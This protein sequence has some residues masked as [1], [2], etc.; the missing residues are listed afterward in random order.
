[1][2]DTYVGLGLAFPEPQDCL[3][4]NT[5]EHGRFTFTQIPEGSRV[6]FWV[7]APGKERVWTF[8][9]N[10]AVQAAQFPVGQT[11]IEIVLEDE[12]IIEGRVIDS[13]SGQGVPGVALLACANRIAAGFFSNHRTISGEDGRFRLS[14]LPADDYSI[15]VVAPHHGQY[16]WVGRDVKV[17]VGTGQSV[18]EVNIPVNKGAMLEVYMKSP[19]TGEPVK[20]ALVIIDQKANFGR[21]DRFSRFVY[22]DKD[23]LAVCRVPAGECTILAGGDEYIYFRDPEPIKAVKGKT[24]RRTIELYKKASVEGIVT[25]QQGNPVSNAFIDCMPNYDIPVRSDA[26]GEY[27]VILDEYDAKKRFLLVRDQDKCQAARVEIKPDTMTLDVTLEPAYRLLGQVLDPNGKGIPMASIKSHVVPEVFTDAQGR[28][29]ISAVT[30]QT[31]SIEVEADGYGRFESDRIVVDGYPNKVIEVDP[32]V[33]QPGSESISGIVVDA[34]DNPVVG[35]RMLITGSLGS[36]TGQPELEGFTD[37]HGR[38]SFRGVCKGPLQVQAGFSNGRRGCG[39]TNAQGGDEEVKLVL[40]RT[41]THEGYKSLAGKPL[42]DFD[43]ITID[44]DEERSRNKA[45][46][47]CF[48]DMQQRPSRHWVAQL[49]KR[50]EELKEKDMVVVGVQASKMEKSALDEWVRKQG[51]SFPVGTI[52]GDERER[53]FEWGIKSLPWLILTDGEHIVRLE[54]AGLGEVGQMLKET[55]DGQD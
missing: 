2:N 26:D 49:A 5:D 40:G 41:L 12:S 24:H 27:R 44:Y 39:A 52:E 21:H 6:D 11:D 55:R 31:Y 48:F 7:E 34:N 18:K 1:M 23:G 46:L 37:K 28:Y 43:G 36:H 35:I 54:G 9:D 45:I 14:G 53:R 15:Q 17:S 30:A 20:G 16:E 8:W 22:S 13:D 33:L 32:I 47:M 3:R 38:F 50:T 4:S 29:E 51:I 19:D 42:P 10:D 25:D